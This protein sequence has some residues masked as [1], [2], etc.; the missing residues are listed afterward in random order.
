MAYELIILVVITPLLLFVDSLLWFA[1]GVI[2]LLLLARWHQT[3]RLARS[4]PSNL[5]LLVFVLLVPLTYF[6][7][8]TPELT[9]TYLGYLIA[10]IALYQGVINSTLS[11]IRLG[12]LLVALLFVASILAVVSPLLVK[13]L[14]REGANSFLP[15]VVRAL[16]QRL[17]EHVNAN[18]MAGT[19]AVW[20]PL[21]LVMA[22]RPC[23]LQVHHRP[24][25]R[26]V[27]LAGSALMLAAMLMLSARGVWLALAVAACLAAALR[28]PRAWRLTPFV[29][30]I[31]W[32]GLV[33][34]WYERLAQVLFSQDSLGGF[35]VRVD[36]W[37]RGL[38]ALQDFALTG[39]GIGSWGKLGPLLYPT[40]LISTAQDIPHVHNL[41]LQVG[42]DLGVFGLAA[43]IGLLLLSFRLAHTARRRFLASGAGDLAA[44]SLAV[45]TGLAVMMVHGL[46][47]AVSWS[48]KPAVLAWCLLAVAMVLY[49]LSD[50]R[51][52]GVR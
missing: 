4:A 35:A 31:G 17:P 29:L 10:G 46:L 15:P 37:S 47:D 49:L 22:W 5:L 2:G 50:E 1:T 8:V 51:A 38:A 9:R 21:A 25:L 28:W 23:C 3:G 34:G 11:R 32:L 43:Y 27:A 24:L 33:Q 36:I 39:M 40:G 48:A 14:S 18:V 19:L 16:G 7:S 41:L 20:L 30:A 45:W 12:W 13:D 26:G 44:L 6:V 42:V 52:Q